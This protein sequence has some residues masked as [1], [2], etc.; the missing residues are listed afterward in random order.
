MISPFRIVEADWPNDIALLKTV[1]E[2]VFVKE[3]GVPL[4][5]EWD[6]LDINA[7]HFVALDGSYH[8]IGTVRILIN[9]QVGRMAVLPE[10]RGKGVGSALLKAAMN[11]VKGTL[12]LN[13]QATATSFYQ[14]FGFVTEG[15]PF[16]DAGIPHRK[17]VLHR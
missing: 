1:R 16:L 5:L 14:R 11:T 17:M 12:R 13:A 7:R 4:N 15:P 6:G 9:G 3:Q 10:W 2:A 8:A